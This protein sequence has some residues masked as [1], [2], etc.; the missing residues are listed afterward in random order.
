MGEQFAIV[1]TLIYTQTKK[2]YPLD[3]Y[4]CEFQMYEHI[5][6]K[7]S[8]YKLWSFRND[9]H[10]R[11]IHLIISEA[12][13]KAVNTSTLKIKSHNIS[14]VCVRQSSEPFKHI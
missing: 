14:R 9:L 8:S 5:S 12:A 3:D 6:I 4:V 2:L 13:D 1:A 11:V 7:F 10:W